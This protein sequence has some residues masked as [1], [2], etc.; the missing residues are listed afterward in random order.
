MTKLIFMFV[1]VLCLAA[2]VLLSIQSNSTADEAREKSVEAN[3]KAD[4]AASKSELAV[5]IAQSADQKSSIALSQSQQNGAAIVAIASMHNQNFLVLGFALIAATLLVIYFV[6]VLPEVERRKHAEI[7]LSMH[8]LAALQAAMQRQI[9]S[10][11]SVTI[12]YRVVQKPD[13]IQS[14]FLIGDGK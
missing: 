8:K 13:D 12:P 5:Q 3:Q 10:Q 11:S 6:R 14:S 7:E 1:L 4:D 9:E 2:S